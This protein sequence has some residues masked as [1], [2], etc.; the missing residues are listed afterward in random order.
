MNFLGRDFEIELMK[1]I[2]DK[3]AA[4]FIVMKGRRRI[5]KSRLIEEFGKNFDHC[6]CFSGMPPAT[7]TTNQDQINEFSVQL[8][9]NFNIPMAYYN[10]W[11]DV[12]WAL[13]GR[14]Q[15]GKVLVFFDEI[16]WMGSKDPNFLGKIKNFWDMHLKKNDNLMFVVCGSAS[17]WINAN[18]LNSTGFVGRISHTITLKELPLS[19]C[20]KFW[21]K[22]IS[23][24][25]KC[26]VLSITGG[27]PRYLEEI[28]F[29]YSAED[30]IK[31]MCFTEGGLLVEEFDHIFSD[32]FLRESEFYKK[33]LEVLETGPKDYT[34]ILEELG[35]SSPGRLL[36]YLEELNIAG[37]ITRDYT[38]NIRNGKDSKLSQ[39]RLQDN[40]LRFY[41]KYIAPNRDK[42]KRG[43]F[44]IKS[45][46][47][48][49][50]WYSMIG[51]QFEN[52]ILSNRNDIHRILG[53]MPEE[54]ISSNPYFQRKTMRTKGCQIDYMVQTKFD[55]LYICEI[56]FSKNP[57]DD[58]IVYEIQS[59]ID[60]LQ[61]RKRF[62]CRP[63]LIHVNGVTDDVRDSD[64]F[65]RIIDIK[66]LM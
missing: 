62:S 40:Y 47:S 12:L 60:A 3:K 15:A 6:Y 59:K 34:V 24:Y 16:S 57:I 21:P 18:I 39:Y 58:S 27:V 13:A 1:R 37:F 56:K 38:W 52:L 10:D 26:K 2:A 20:S 7:E 63:V 25:E 41:L 5:G 44:A 54:I 8:S 51:L 49:P 50:E 45:L 33:I 14:V 32:V 65:A 48:L 29:K 17:S 64:F 19:D 43:I 30:N 61:H 35:L 66:E 9:Q 36:E 23:V 42:I 46:T 4:S 22:N 31:R 11:S 28:N 55:T 53:I